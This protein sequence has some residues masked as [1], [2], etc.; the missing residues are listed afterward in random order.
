[1][2]DNLKKDSSQKSGSKKHQQPQQ[3]CTDRTDVA[4]GENSDGTS[5]DP[6]DL[7]QKVDCS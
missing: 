1:M 6:E 2:N 3:C 7:L 4:Y 5:D